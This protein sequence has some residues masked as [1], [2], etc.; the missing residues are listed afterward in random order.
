LQ[1]KIVLK[2]FLNIN[3]SIHSVLDHFT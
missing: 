1:N 3:R 2:I